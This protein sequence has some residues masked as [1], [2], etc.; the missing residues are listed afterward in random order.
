MLN[1]ALNITKG[2]DLGLQ[3]RRAESFVFTP[4]WSGFDYMRRQSQVR[5]AANL[6][7]GFR[8]TD[9]FGNG[10]ATVGTAMA[11]SGA[12]FNSNAG[13][14]TSPPLAFLLTIFGVR[15]GWWAGNPRKN[16]WEMEGPSN[17]LEYL[18]REL[19]AQLDTDRE[20]VL[21]TDGGHFENMGLYELVRRRCRYIVISDAEEDEKFKLE[22]I[23][24][25][26]RK[27]R[28]DFGT[29]SDLL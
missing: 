22:G 20:F 26:V 27:C 2:Q 11:I 1:T 25:A 7:F 12:A 6:E 14:H 3:E 9:L 10:G 21:L 5:Q 16:K 19:T 24:G 13:N 4:L 23:G 18:A 29:I 15:L 28:T 17:S 8:R